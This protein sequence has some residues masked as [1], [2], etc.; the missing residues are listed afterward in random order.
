M[1]ILKNKDFVIIYIL[2]T[3]SKQHRSSWF[4]TMKEDAYILKDAVFFYLYY[5][6]YFYIS[7]ILI[8]YMVSNPPAFA[9][10]VSYL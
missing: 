4:L 6:F 3:I 5:I 7:I 8:F 10:P 9:I 2:L 1:Y